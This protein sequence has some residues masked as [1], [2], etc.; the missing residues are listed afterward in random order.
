MK[1]INTLIVGILLSF[2]SLA[3][4]TIDDM[5]GLSTD[6]VTVH[7]RSVEHC[8]DTITY[9]IKTSVNSRSTDGLLNVDNLTQ[10]ALIFPYP[11]D[12]ADDVKVSIKFPTPVKN[13]RIAVSDIDDDQ[14][15]S[16]TIGEWLDNFNVFPDYIEQFQNQAVFVDLG[17]GRIDPADSNNTAGWLVWEGPLDSISFMYHSDSLFAYGAFIEEIQFE[18]VSQSNLSVIENVEKNIS[19]TIYPNP[20]TTNQIEVIVNDFSFEMNKV[21]LYNSEGKPLYSQKVNQQNFVIDA[22]QLP[23]GVTNM[24]VVSKYGEKL[25]GKIIKN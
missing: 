7:N 22:N 9:T 25:N 6:G 11:T 19:L 4:I 23:L 12:T 18:C 15:T 17:N 21:F 3:Q 2:M 5:S 16:F 10:S 14:Y 1:N 24:I 8:G 20:V 13:L